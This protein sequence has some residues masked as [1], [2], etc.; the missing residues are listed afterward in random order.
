MLIGPARMNLQRDLIEKKRKK[1]RLTPLHDMAEGVTENVVPDEV[2][3][4]RDAV[5]PGNSY[6]PLSV[7]ISPADFTRGL[8][9]EGQAA[10]SPGNC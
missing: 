10:D 1:E 9:T 4:F 6:P 2:K 3:A 5:D 8:I 7:N